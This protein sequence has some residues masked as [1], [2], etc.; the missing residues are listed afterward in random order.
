MQSILAS[1]AAEGQLWC[2]VWLV[3]QAFRSSCW[4]VLLVFRWQIVGSR[5]GVVCVWVGLLEKVFALFFYL[6]VLPLNEM[7][8]SSS[9]K[10]GKKKKKKGPTSQPTQPN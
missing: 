9:K 5:C 2:G 6:C 10:I 8:G 7:T 1:V 3:P 4:D